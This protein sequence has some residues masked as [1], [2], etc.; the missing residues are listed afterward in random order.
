MIDEGSFAKNVWRES[1]FAY[2]LSCAK[3]EK[4]KVNRLK[5]II[6]AFSEKK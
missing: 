1:D 4:K 6:D 2:S 5:S 3:K